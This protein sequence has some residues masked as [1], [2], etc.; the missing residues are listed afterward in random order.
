[1]SDTGSPGTRRIAPNTMIETPKRIPID[2]TVRLRRKLGLM[3]WAARRAP[4][5]PQ[6]GGAASA[7]PG[8][9]HHD[10][11]GINPAESGRERDRSDLVGVP[12]QA[13]LLAAGED[14][15]CLVPQELL[16][17]LQQ[18]DAL[19]R[20]Q[21]GA[22]GIDERVVVLVRPEGEVPLSRGDA[23]GGPARKP[24]KWIG[25]RRRVTCVRK[26]AAPRAED[27]GVRVVV[28]GGVE[29]LEIDLEPDV[30]KVAHGYGGLR[31]LPTRL[32]LPHHE[33]HGEV[34]TVLLPDLAARRQ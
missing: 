10:G 17:V 29:D 1:M 18:L 32:T 3:T 21:L 33:V 16:R 20:V 24:V 31:A 23:R 27:A 4:A 5:L 34:P 26:V 11:P 15:R 6:A 7:P 8:S 30:L 12:R 13:G 9:L 25:E 19:V 14:D 2:A 22:R 28:S